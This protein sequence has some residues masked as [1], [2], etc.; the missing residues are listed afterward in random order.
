MSHDIQ[1]VLATPNDIPILIDYR[2]RFLSEHFGPQND[3]VVTAFKQAMQK[4]F[5]VALIS[6][7]YICWYAVSGDVV[8][9]IGGLVIRLR[10][11]NFINV[12]G[13]EA[14]IMSMYTLPEYRRQ[15]IA[16]GI[17]QRLIN[18]AS[19]LGVKVFELHATEEGEP[20]YIKEGFKKH[21][22]PTYRKYL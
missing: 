21:H 20:V 10:P 14:Y 8:A 12:E 15:G 22:E 11:G 4:Y 6:K 13:K 1:F 7:D 18:S 16:A 2:I 17:A 5:E 19:E 3:D 9:G